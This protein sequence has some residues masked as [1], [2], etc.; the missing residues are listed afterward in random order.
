MLEQSL[1]RAE[2]NNVR[3]S[4]ESPRS[5]VQSVRSFGFEKI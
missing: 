2:A 5:E 4:R 1:P 3:E